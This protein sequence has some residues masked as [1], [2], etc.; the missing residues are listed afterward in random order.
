MMHPL[1]AVILGIVEGVTEYLPVSSTGHLILASAAM[2]LNEPESLKRAVDSFS[3]II[4]SGAI[5]AVVSLYW[6]R[7]VQMLRGVLG[8]D[9]AGRRLLINL[10]IAFLPAMLTWPIIFPLVK[11]HL[12]RPIP[13]LS[14]ILLGGVWMIWIDRWR[15]RRFGDAS[16]ATPET[17]GYELEEI[18]PRRALLIGVFQWA[19]L[20]PGTSRALMTIGGGM[21]LGL[22]PR[23]AA[24]FSFLLGLPTIG[25]ACVYETYGLW[26]ASRAEDA[27]AF[28]SFFDAIPLGVAVLGFATSAVVAAVV[29]KWFVGFLE[30]C[31]LGFF[32]WYRIGL[33]VVMLMLLMAGAIAL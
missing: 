23:A 9:E 18:T 17:G 25:A 12:F 33:F 15:A 4:Q 16:E 29:V 1:H 26:K 24:E 6:P 22:R 28:G 13:T 27:T 2:G 11:D 21:V 10:I 31:G 3:I 30:R 5:L 7:L 19:S 32:G 14:A 8:K 20:W